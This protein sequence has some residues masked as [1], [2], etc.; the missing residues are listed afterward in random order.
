MVVR[1]A[2]VNIPEDKRV[3]VALTYIFGIGRAISND[4]LKLAK[5]DPN[6]RVHKLSESEVATLRDYIEKGDLQVE[7]DLRRRVS[8]D[9][10]RLKDMG[11]YRG[12]RHA[13]NLPVRGQKTRTN[14]RTKRGKRMTMGS[15]RRKATEKT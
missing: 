15:G 7:G 13:K 14:A 6:V 3:E 10:K 4:I 2:G 5:I 9:I 12:L 1:I 8:S 11:A